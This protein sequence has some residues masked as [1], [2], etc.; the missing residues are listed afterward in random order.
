MRMIIVII[1]RLKNTRTLFVNFL[2]KGIVLLGILL[3]NT[4]SIA[5]PIPHTWHNIV[6]EQ[7][8]WRGKLAVI[9]EGA[10]FVKPDGAEV[11]DFTVASNQPF[12]F[13][14]AFD[15]DDDFDV[16]YTLTLTQQEPAKKVVSKTCV[17]VVT[18]KGPA[19]P[20]IH[21]LSYNGATCN[22]VYV[23]RVGEDFTAA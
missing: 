16:A 15:A 2:K 23:P 8:V 14:F 5:T 22:S 3:C 11:S 9:N 17:F 12:K 21:N 6:V 13:G 4:P 20:D 18:A 1:W 10:V 7:G 19:N